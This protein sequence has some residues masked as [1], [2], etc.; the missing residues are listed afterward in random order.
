VELSKIPD[1]VLLLKRLAVIANNDYGMLRK[2]DGKTS[3]VSV[4]RE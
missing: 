4:D 2:D 3:S 1:L